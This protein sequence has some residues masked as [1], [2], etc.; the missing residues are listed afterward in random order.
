M[1]HLGEWM[2]IGCAFCWALA[3][4]L[5]RRVG[6]ADPWA[7]NLFK[8]VVATVLLVAT[9]LAVGI[10]L[11][12]DRSTTDWLRL[13]GSALLGITVGDTLFFAGLQRIGGSVA[14]VVDCAYS[15]TVVVLSVLLLGETLRGG[16]LL[17]APLVVAGLLLVT[18]QPRP[19][20]GQAVE[21]TVS[22]AGVLLALGGVLST[23]LGVIVA[24]PALERSNLIEAT[25]VRLV[26]ATVSIA[27]R[28]LQ[29]AHRPATRALFGS[30]QA[31][32]NL[33]PASVVG[34][35]LSMLLWLGGLKYA[36]ASVASLLNQLSTVFLLVLARVVGGEIVPAR[37]WTG[38][39]VALA[40][41]V[42]IVL[43]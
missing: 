4:T 21:P 2:A 3:V 19:S 1:S 43:G 40:G 37:R 41:T 14:A 5:F 13:A 28:Q 22:R 36:P 26:V 11:D 6:I 34:T 30:P 17:G 8:N 23:A 20:A 39:A 10:P 38:A 7:L 25:T 24:K 31:W 29:A 33:V 42:V 9:M 32:R 27:L 18:W 12:T 16:L 15:P 35:Y